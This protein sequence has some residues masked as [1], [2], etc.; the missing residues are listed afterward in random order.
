[1]LAVICNKTLFR[2]PGW[3]LA[4]WVAVIFVAI[5]FLLGTIRTGRSFKRSSA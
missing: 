3:V 2:T 4:L 5:A 1:M